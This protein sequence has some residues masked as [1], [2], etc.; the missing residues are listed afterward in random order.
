MNESTLLITGANR[1]LGLEWVRQASAD[2]WRVHATCRNPE[3]ATSLQAIAQAS[4]G[5]VQVHPLE[6][7]DQTS[8]AALAAALRD[9]PIDVLVNNA[10]VYGQPDG[11]FGKTDRA[12][13]LK[14][15]DINVIAVMQ[16]MEAFAPHVAASRIRQML[17]ISSKMGSLADNTSG[18][19]YVYRSAKAALNMVVKSASID[20]APRGITVVALHPGWVKTDMGGPNAMTE[21]Y[22]SVRAMRGIAAGLGAMD[23][24]RFIG[25]DGKDIPW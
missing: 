19:V 24:G 12:V 4:G 13:W 10:G 6:V 25:P 7:T 5:R 9:T 11:G 14:T 3:S 15:F 16:L 22:D 18:G 23:A 21:V 8:L 2:G 17:A 20:L 1:G